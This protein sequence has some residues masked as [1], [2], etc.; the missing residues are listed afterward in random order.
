MPAINS[1][2]STITK[3]DETCNYSAIYIRID[4]KAIDR[5]IAS[6]NY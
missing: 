2:T 3:G 1:N 5:P 4:I 6:G